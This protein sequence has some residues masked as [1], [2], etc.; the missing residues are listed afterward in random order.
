MLINVGRQ[1]IRSHDRRRS[2]TP[3]D[4]HQNIARGKLRPFEF[5]LMNAQTNEFE[6]REIELVAF[7]IEDSE[8]SDPGICIGF[9][10]P[11]RRCST[12]NRRLTE[13][14]QMTEG[15]RA[16]C[17]RAIHSLK[18]WMMITRINPSSDNQALQGYSK[19][20]AVV[21]G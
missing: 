19:D 3:S 10:V 21:L 7:D 16:L 8:E 5:L 17:Q 11:F 4:C 9:L 20:P 1:N 2:N 14:R 13:V 12:T 15:V 6:V 18:S